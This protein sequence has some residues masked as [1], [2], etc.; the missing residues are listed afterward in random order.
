MALTAQP[1]PLCFTVHPQGA[2]VRGCQPERS[3]HKRIER[4]SG[5]RFRRR[6]HMEPLTGDSRARS[7]LRRRVRRGCA[8]Y[9]ESGIGMVC[10]KRTTVLPD[11][12]P[13][14][15]NG[16]PAKRDVTMRHRGTAEATSTVRFS[17][18]CRILD[19]I[20][21]PL[22]EGFVGSRS[23]G[24]TGSIVGL[25]QDAISWMPRQGRCLAG[26]L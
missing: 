21:P 6:G 2:G 26:T 10:A 19:T 8:P 16:T 23:R 24:I 14:G 15:M 4:Q 25:I 12:I 13:P 5:S 11:R 20:G 9:I 7:D 1:Q 22:G 3:F 18:H 17:R